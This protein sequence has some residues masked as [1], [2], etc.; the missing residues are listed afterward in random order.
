VPGCHAVISKR[1]NIYSIGPTG[2]GVATFSHSDGGVSSVSV[3]AADFPTWIMSM[4]R[5]Q[6]RKALGSL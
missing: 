4:S 6:H 1:G 2:L 3:R 5:C